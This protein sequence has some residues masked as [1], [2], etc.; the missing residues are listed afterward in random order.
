MHFLEIQCSVSF[1]NLENSQVSKEM[2]ASPLAATELLNEAQE[3]G[4]SILC[5]LRP[6]RNSPKKDPQEMSEEIN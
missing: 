2:K 3:T 1:G 4:S 5:L 6:L